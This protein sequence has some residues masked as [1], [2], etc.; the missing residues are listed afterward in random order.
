[1]GAKKGQSRNPAAAGRQR[2]GL[3]VFGVLLAAL[4]LWF[5][6]AQGL[7]APGVPSGNVALVEEVPAEVGEISEADFKRAL[8]QKAAEDGLKKAPGLGDDK[9]EELKEAALGELLD[10]VWLQGEAEELGIEVTPKQIETELAQIKKQNWKTE[11]EYQQ[12]LKT[13]RFTQEDVIERVRLQILSTQIQEQM[14]SLAT[15]ATDEEI[16]SFY[17]VERD[18][19]FTEPET[20]EARIV[21]NEDRAKVEQAKAQL[22]AD[23]SPESWKK[24]AAKISEDPTT[25]GK[26]GVQA[27]LT[28]ELLQS[29]PELA[30]AVF[31]NDTGVIVGPTPVAGKYFVT[32]VVKVN[33]LKTQGLDEVRAQIKSQLDQQ[34]QQAFFSEFVLD[35]Q[36][37]WESRTFCADGY[38]IERCSNY[39]GDGRP[40]S[41]PPACYEADPKGGIPADCPAPVQQPAP[42]LPGTVTLAKPDGERLPQRPRPLGLKESPAPE[43]GLPGGAAPP[44]L[45]E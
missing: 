28:R 31:D 15:P 42:A 44:P 30:G 38:V 36:T 10:T 25:K 6:I 40:A 34:L 41:A 22:E 17:E 5:A 32:E 18:A 21:V 9:Y 24:I 11:A 43:L 1:M 29:Q 16:E 3:V 19:Q 2:L 23:S 20:R 26:G 8:L 7:G 33:P 12:F 27:G 13:S 45:P 4:F 37:K 14:T 39:T 35:Y